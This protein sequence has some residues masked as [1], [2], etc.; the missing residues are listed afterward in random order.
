M[1]LLEI[2]DSNI[3]RLLETFNKTID[4]QGFIIDRETKE[5]VK[6]R[7]TGK[8]IK[9]E[10]LGGILPGSDIFILDSDVAYARYVMEFLADNDE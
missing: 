10:N 4:E 3:D 7:Y 5:K 2:N 8:Y 9:K 6:C 1:E